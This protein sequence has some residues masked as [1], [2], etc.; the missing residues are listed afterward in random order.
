[1]DAAGEDEDGEE[2]SEAEEAQQGECSS[3]AAR[4]DLA[5]EGLPSSEQQD[6]MDISLQHRVPSAAD[7]ET[8]QKAAGA[9]GIA[10]DDGEYPVR[11]MQFKCAPNCSRKNS[12]PCAL[13]MMRTSRRQPLDGSCLELRELLLVLVFVLDSYTY[14]VVH[15]ILLFKYHTH[16]TLLFL[17]LL[18]NL[19]Y[20]CCRW[21]EGR[22]E[23]DPITRSHYRH[24]TEASADDPAPLVPGG[25]PCIRITF[26]GASFMLH[27]IRHMVGAAV[28]VSR[29]LLPLV[30]VE[31]CLRAPARA[32]MPL[33]PAHVRCL[34]AHSHHPCTLRGLLFCRVRCS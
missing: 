13:H 5:T 29:G 26:R 28:G 9:D 31:A 12:T 6:G 27:Q 11:V 30:W 33:A 16:T 17:Q 23:A 32:Y 19:R 24:I 20:A 21:T 34:A 15:F 14:T 10:C 7:A 4:S 2:Q 3:A 1:M 22:S 18:W 8:N 25:Q